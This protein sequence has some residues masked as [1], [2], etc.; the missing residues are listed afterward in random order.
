MLMRSCKDIT[1]VKKA[2]G[3]SSLEMTEKYIKTSEKE[4]REA[5]RELFG[6][7]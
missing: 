4:V 7:K 2:L 5:V 1:I 6:D 3:H